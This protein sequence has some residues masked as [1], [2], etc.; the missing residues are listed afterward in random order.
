MMTLYRSGNGKF[1]EKYFV[2]HYFCVALHPKF[3]VLCAED[4]VQR[5]KMH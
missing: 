4:I 2:L 1:R 5:L 3:S